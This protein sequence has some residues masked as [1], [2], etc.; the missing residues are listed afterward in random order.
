[1]LFS[2]VY[3]YWWLQSQGHVGKEMIYHKLLQELPDS[4]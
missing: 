2:T 1:M 4:L 3:Y